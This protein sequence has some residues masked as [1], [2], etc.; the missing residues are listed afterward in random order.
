[1]N[2]RNVFIF[3]LTKDPIHGRKMILTECGRILFM[4]SFVN[5][6]LMALSRDITNSNMV[7]NLCCPSIITITF[8][9]VSPHYGYK[10]CI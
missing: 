7:V 8:D 3:P 4:V 5:F 2:R 6:F 9:G 1:M 10:K